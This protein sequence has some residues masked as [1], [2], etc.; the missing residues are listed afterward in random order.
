MTAAGG[1][2]PPRAAPCSLLAPTGPRRRSAT[3]RADLE[4]LRR[5]AHAHGASV[6]DVGRGEQVDALRT[7]V[8]VTGRRA[9]SAD[10]PGNRVAPLLVTVPATGT[11]VE[12]L[13]RTAGAVGAARATAAAQP[14]IAMLQPL[15]RLIAAAGL[16]R[17]Y[18]NQ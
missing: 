8:M 3:A 6:N 14:P 17:R 9:T 15:F 13:H 1:V 2:F 16:Y 18:M 11:A 10:A 5:A 7:A 4:A 12:R